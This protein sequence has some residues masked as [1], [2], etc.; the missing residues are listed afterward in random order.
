M[1]HKL[2]SKAFAHFNT[3][4]IKS[5]KAYPYGQIEDIV[6]LFWQNGKGEL[7]FRFSKAVGDKGG[8]NPLQYS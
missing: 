3:S 8:G 5:N 2:G 6:T 4:L 7:N 1:V